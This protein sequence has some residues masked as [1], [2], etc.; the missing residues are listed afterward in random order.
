MFSV[1]AGPVRAAVTAPEFRWT[2]FFCLVSVFIASAMA[3][4][5]SSSTAS[6]SPRSNHSRAIPIAMSG[7]FW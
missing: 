5:L 2:L 1:Q 3:L 7:L 6:T 4:L